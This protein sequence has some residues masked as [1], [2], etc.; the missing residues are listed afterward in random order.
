MI[1]AVKQPAPDRR[2]GGVDSESL[3]LLQRMAAQ[4][5]GLPERLRGRL[6]GDT[7]GAL[8]ADAKKLAV[9]LG[10]VQPQA[11]DAG[12]RFTMNDEIRR[13]AGYP[14]AG[15]AP[16]PPVGDIGVGR[17]GSALPRRPAAPDMNSLIR[18]T[19]HGR[20]SVAHQFAEQ[21]AT[22]EAS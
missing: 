5:A 20:R 2:I 17:G 7:I 10:Y 13:R 16:E 8:R 12:G 22:E 21:I 4:E 15:P 18:G 19:Y 3:D 14:I 1:S 6:A 11:R 9:D